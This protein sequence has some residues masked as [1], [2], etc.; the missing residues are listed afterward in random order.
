MDLCL[1]LCAAVGKT[2][3]LGLA[4][5]SKA[6]HAH[7]CAARACRVKHV[8]RLGYT[9]FLVG[10]MDKEIGEELVKQG[11]PSFAM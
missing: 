11:V 3:R 10:A 4:H 2:K 5:A 1:A 9:N 6:T 8:R 7:G